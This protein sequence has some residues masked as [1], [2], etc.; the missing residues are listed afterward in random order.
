[1]KTQNLMQVTVGH[2]LHQTENVIGL[3]PNSNMHYYF[4]LGKRKGKRRIY[5][6]YYWPKN[7]YVVQSNTFHEIF[8]EFEDRSDIKNEHIERKEYHGIF[9]ERIMWNCSRSIENQWYLLTENFWLHRRHISRMI[10]QRK[11]GTFPS[12]YPRVLTTS[13]TWAITEH[14]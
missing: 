3:N 12:R 4:C 1:M 5:R 8:C 10:I 6:N 14:L 11:R 2:S 13:W 7:E 9:P